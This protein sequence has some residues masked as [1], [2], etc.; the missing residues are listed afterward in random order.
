MTTE[1]LPYLPPMETDAWK[2]VIG[3]D[4]HDLPLR[5][6]RAFYLLHEPVMVMGRGWFPELTPYW[7]NLMALNA[8]ETQWMLKDMAD[9]LK[10][11]EDD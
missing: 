2:R 11:I 1:P 10:E 4:F 8:T 3:G 5:K 6:R 7:A 9:R